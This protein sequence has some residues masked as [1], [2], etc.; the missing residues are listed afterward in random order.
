M[1]ID[2]IKLQLLLAE[3]QLTS[4][5]L[6]EKAGV[7]QLTITKIMQDKKVKPITIGKIAAALDIDPVELII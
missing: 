2:K 7:S 3:K 4:K 6:A 5:E 1:E